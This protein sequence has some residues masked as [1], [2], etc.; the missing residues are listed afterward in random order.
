MFGFFFF[1]FR[2]IVKNYIK[3]VGTMQALGEKIGICIFVI[4]AVLSARRSVPGTGGS[5]CVLVRAAK[6]HI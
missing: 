6:D 2:R 1:F 3:Q 4:A 5:Q